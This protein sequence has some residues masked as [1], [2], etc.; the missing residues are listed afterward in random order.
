MAT[1][2]SAVMELRLLAEEALDVTVDPGSDGT[3]PVEVTIGSGG[4]RW[5]N[6]GASGQVGAC[7]K[8]LR[9]VGI[10]GTDSYDLL[11]AGALKTPAG[12]T[13]DADEL[14]G[15]VLKVTSGAC[16]LQAP[17]ASGLGIFTAASQG[18]QLS[19]TGGLRSVALYFGPDGLDVTTNSKFDIV[20]SSGAATATYELILIVA[21]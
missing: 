11:A 10:S 2:F 1:K 8:R 17:A 18:L 12:A 4:A 21:E 14:K 16:K 13:I 7:Y 19:A 6:G 3:L 20:E 9:T 15:L 5:A